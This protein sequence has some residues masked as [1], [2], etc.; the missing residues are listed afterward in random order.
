ME[1]GNIKSIVQMARG[2]IEERI[3][4]EMTKVLE[5]ILDT[6]TKATAKRKLTVTFEIQP[7]DERQT[8]AVAATAKSTLAP[9]NPVATALYVGKVGE[10]IQA[11]EMTAQIPGQAD[12]FGGE[13][14][15]PAQLKLVS[16]R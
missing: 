3:D 10:E 12:L 15:T 16:S 9:T 5:N 1:T 7:D 13:Q 4:L 6:N 11:V 2:A 14:E 8:L